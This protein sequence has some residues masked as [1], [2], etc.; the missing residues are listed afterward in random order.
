MFKYSTV[1]RLVPLRNAYK[2]CSTG[3][4]TKTQ[5]RK[6]ANTYRQCALLLY[7]K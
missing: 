7:D 6:V 3:S 5:H 4:I 2:H 1:I